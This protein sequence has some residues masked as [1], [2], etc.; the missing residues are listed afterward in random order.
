MNNIQQFAKE[1]TELS[2]KHGL[3]LGADIY[4]QVCVSPI[5][6]SEQHSSFRYVVEDNGDAIQWLICGERKEPERAPKPLE[7]SSLRSEQ[8]GRSRAEEARFRE[9]RKIPAEMR[10]WYE[11]KEEP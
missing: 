10:L 8:D 11:P 1:L 4:G 6:Q 5:T 9:S 2:K 7:P 3:I